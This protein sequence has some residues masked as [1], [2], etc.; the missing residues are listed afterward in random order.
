MSRPTRSTVAAST[1]QIGDD[2]AAIHH[3]D[4]VGE[5]KQLFEVLADQK[6]APPPAR[7]CQELAV[8]EFGCADVDAARRLGGEQDSRVARELA[9]EER[10]LQVAAGQCRG[11]RFWPGGAD[12]EARDLLGGELA[13]W[14]CR[15]RMPSRLKGGR[16]IQG[17]AMLSASGSAPIMPI[18]MRSSGTRPTPCACI[19]RGEGASMR[20]AMI[21]I[22]PETGTSTP[23]TTS[24]SSRWP[25]P[26]TPAMP[27]ISPARSVSETSRS[28]APPAPR[29]ET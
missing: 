25:L 14:R 3:R 29:V 4:A 22:E 23:A 5:L 20:S 28:A 15:S 10:L 27:T 19:C 21:A 7:S 2:A 16:S 11:A 26:E 17:S 6:H 9:G 1:R 12:V 8:D 18:V 13:R 24:A